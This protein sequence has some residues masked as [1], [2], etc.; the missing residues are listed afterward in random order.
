M[1]KTRAHRYRDDLASDRARAAE[2]LGDRVICSRCK[3]T[4]A[5]YSE[6]CT[7]ELDDRCEGFE[8]YEAA[9]KTAQLERHA[10]APAAPAAHLTMNG[11]ADP[12]APDFPGQGRADGAPPPAV[13]QSGSLDAENPGRRLA[14]KP[15]MAGTALPGAALCGGKVRHR[16]RFAS[17]DPA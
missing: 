4:L 7:A 5:T 9:L 3:A 6:R 17:G 15:S 2:A 8:T 14:A 12:R 16:T 11:M 13:P 1:T 10:Q